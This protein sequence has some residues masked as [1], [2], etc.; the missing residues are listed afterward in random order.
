M[1]RK[2]RSNRWSGGIRGAT[3]GA[4]VVGCASGGG[5]DDSA[6]SRAGDVAVQAATVRWLIENND[7][8]LGGSASVSPRSP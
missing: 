1:S 5:G 6:E 7:S 3:I 2:E 8:A 4:L